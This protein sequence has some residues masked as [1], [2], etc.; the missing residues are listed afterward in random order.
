MDFHATMSLKSIG[1]I[2]VFHF[3]VEELTTLN[4]VKRKSEVLVKNLFRLLRSKQFQIFLTLCH[5]GPQL[6][7]KPMLVSIGMTRMSLRLIR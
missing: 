7:L 2:M 1:Q 4:Q 5:L 3:T 6:L